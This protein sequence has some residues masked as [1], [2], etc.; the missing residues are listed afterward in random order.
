MTTS[1]PTHALRLTVVNDYTGATDWNTRLTLFDG[2]GGRVGGGDA[3]LTLSLPRGIYTVRPER[4]GEIGPDQTILHERAQELTLPAPRRH[5]AM[6]SLDSAHTHEFLQAA[7][8]HFSRAPSWENP[9]APGDAPLL[10]VLVRATGD[11]DH[12]DVDP[13]E[14]LAIL[15]DTGSVVTRF[16]PDHTARNA[17]EG[18]VAFSAHLPP[19]NYLLGHFRGGRAMALPLLLTRKRWDT[20]V[21]VPHERGARLSAAS[22]DMCPRGQGY[23]PGDLLAQQIDAAIQGLGMRL[24]LLPEDLRLSAIY[25]KFEHPLLGLIGAH[26]HFLGPR[27][28]ERL[29][30]AV[31]HNLWRL[32]EGAPDV[33]ALLLMAD[34]REPEGMPATL[35][36]LNARAEAA[37]GETLDAR[38][39][40]RFPPLLRG[41]LDALVR[42]SLRLPELIAPGS[43]LEAAA[44]ASS[45]EGPWSTWEQPGLLP[46]LFADVPPVVVVRPTPQKL[47]PAIKRAIARESPRAARTIIADDRLGD[48]LDD[49]SARMPGI[50][51]RVARD[52]PEVQLPPMPEVSAP[53]RVRDLVQRLREEAPLSVTVG[54]AAPAPAMIPDDSLPEWLVTLVRE[55]QDAE[56]ADFDPV[57]VAR[58]ANVPLSTVRRAVE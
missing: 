19:G 15:D 10:M 48:L 30:R 42:A 54:T 14:G 3:P 9:D 49:P 39:P 56:G 4:L 26:A 47:Y 2:H 18:W 53:D 41:G 25:G 24:D 20:M 57:A 23:D 43:W 34:E 38:L 32:L 13:A 52:M 45:A 31:L 46:G 50:L 21:F 33:V 51:G 58:M 8:T 5:S 44:N 6:P 55:R 11:G 27:R 29:E 28:Q 22:I 1:D 12:S 35:D 17:A 40:L 7:S 36:E 37:F 16:E